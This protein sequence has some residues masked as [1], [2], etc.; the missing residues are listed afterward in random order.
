MYELSCVRVIESTSYHMYELSCVR[1][2]ESTS[3]REYDWL[4]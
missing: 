4:P 1:V 3:Y 2:I